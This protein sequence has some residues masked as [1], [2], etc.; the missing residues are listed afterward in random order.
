MQ[1][2]HPL[3]QRTQ[4]WFDRVWG[5][6]ELA[7]VD[8]MCTPDVKVHGLGGPMVGVALYRDHVVAPF[9]AAFAQFKV[10]LLDAFVC[11]DLVSM[12]V[13]YTITRHCGE[14]VVIEGAG[15]VRFEDNRLA[16]AWNY[17]DFLSLL[18]QTGDVDA[19]V[20]PTMLGRET[21]QA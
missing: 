10:D 17:M 8:E 12:R 1:A 13:R 5:R 2:D 18:V 7:A 9:Y 19:D 21:A 14:Q 20:L 6:K 15:F 11:D 4:E 3:V 16:E